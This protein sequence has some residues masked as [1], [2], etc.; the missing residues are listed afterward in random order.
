MTELIMRHPNYIF[1]GFWPNFHSRLKL[2]SK[3]FV[4]VKGNKGLF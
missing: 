1:L 3:G 2:E 4:W